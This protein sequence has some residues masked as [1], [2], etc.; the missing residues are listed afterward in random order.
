MNTDTGHADFRRETAALIL[1]YLEVIELMIDL[2]S[3]DPDPL[4]L[5]LAQDLATGR[6]VI[7]FDAGKCRVIHRDHF[8]V[9]DDP[10]D[11]K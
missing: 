3:A 5:E 7:V 10:F 4:A 11:D 9:I 8:H 2:K 1:G 6:R